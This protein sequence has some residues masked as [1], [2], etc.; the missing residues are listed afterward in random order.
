M[1][2]K[3]KSKM[4]HHPHRVMN[5]SQR[6]PLYLMESP[7]S[8]INS[9]KLPTNGTV[10]RYY[11]YTISNRSVRFASTKSNFS[12]PMARNTSDMNCKFLSDKPCNE[13]T[14]VNCV[15]RKIVNIW[16]SCG[17]GNYLI[18]EQSIK[19]KF[20]K[21][22]KQWKK[23]GKKKDITQV[24]VQ[25]FKDLMNGL[26]DIASHN[27]E[28]LM[29][30]DHS[31]P[32]TQESIIEDMQFLE[33]QR[34]VRK[35]EISHQCD[36]EL[37][38]KVRRRTERY[39][40]HDEYRKKIIAQGLCNPFPDD[41]D[42][43][44]LSNSASEI[45]GLL[46]ETKSPPDVDDDDELHLTVL[47]DSQKKSSKSSILPQNSGKKRATPCSV[48]VTV[49][50][51]IS[52][53][54]LVEATTP[55][56]VRSGLSYRDQTMFLAAIV[57]YLDVPLKEVGLSRESVRRKR[58]E[59]VQRHGDEIRSDYMEEMAGKHLVLH[60]DGKIIKHIE[61]ESQQ[62]TSADR[63]AISVTSP[64]FGH[65]ED[66]LLG[67]VPSQSGKSADCAICIQNL[68]EYFEVCDG[69][70]GICADTTA[71]NTGRKNGAIVILA[72]VLQKPF[73]WLLCRH[74]IS[75]LMIKACYQ[76]VTGEKTVGPSRKMFTDFK[77]DWTE[78]YHPALSEP[79]ATG[80]FKKINESRLHVGS[81]LHRI[82]LESKSFIAYALEHEVFPRGDY[83]HLVYYLAFAMNVKSTKLDNFKIHQ[84]GACHD[85]RF[86]AYAIYL[87]ML[88]ITSPVLDYLTESQTE[89]VEKMTTIIAVYYGPAFL[90]SSKTEHAVLNDFNS[91]KVAA[92]LGKEFDEEVGRS[93]EKTLSNHTEY[94]SPK[95]I[96]M[97]LADPDLAFETKTKLLKVIMDHKV[98]D[99]TEISK[100]APE[101]VVVTDDT[102]LESLITQ[103]SWLIFLLLGIES[104]VEKWW[105]ATTE[106]VDFQKM[107]SFKWF[108]EFIRNLSCTNDC[109]ERNIGL[110]QKFVSSSI[111]EDQRQNVLLVV[112][113]NRKLV[114]KNMPQSELAKLKTNQG[115]TYS[116][117]TFIFLSKLLIKLK[118]IFHLTIF[119]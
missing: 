54:G 93:L 19:V 51:E 78:K 103:E 101:K 7:L 16:E 89:M 74:H 98:P 15:L 30:S 29:K 65:K 58:Y 111:N 4:N 38:E 49:D 71:A 1:G 44:M 13:E 83:Q 63:I 26:F 94:L 70:F 47:E 82:Y 37:E 14:G 6:R 46:E 5:Y 61:E 76:A 34:S 73:L 3:K 40:R 96:P 62:C 22:H 52:L 91:F 113:E 55:L 100:T 112:R 67:V 118:T 90:K 31:M 97:A 69:I 9:S 88:D 27:F 32:R 24:K 99:I 45:G 79:G 41:E 17:F 35:M 20:E 80:Q 107:D 116:I 39:K 57:N 68:C 110:I 105:I 108:E 21:L 11:Q 23:L 104:K 59:F 81:D 85:A 12:C 77:D 115:Y 106:G 50:K 33:D 119:F 75:E 36:F 43:D 10:L 109:A 48:S 66:L 92:I 8:E 87:V 2:P 25:Q 72:Q 84:P 95:C 53:E 64:E 18:T 28:K 56:S 102:T 60:F 117:Q 114:S 86:M 42:H